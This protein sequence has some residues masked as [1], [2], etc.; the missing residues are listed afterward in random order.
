[1]HTHKRLLYFLFGLILLSLCNI[2]L[3]WFCYTIYIANSASI[4]GGSEVKASDSNA[5]DPDSIPGLGRSPGEGNGN[6]L[7]Y[8]CLENLMDRGLVGY[9]PWGHKESD[10]TER[11]LSLSLSL[12]LSFFEAFT[13]LKWAK[14]FLGCFQSCPAITTLSI[15][16]YF[17]LTQK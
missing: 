2:V 7:Q 3:F 17:S 14:W 4:L 11:L 13:S 5:G 10:M 9:S 8:S 16:E 6:P 15:S 12:S 1:M